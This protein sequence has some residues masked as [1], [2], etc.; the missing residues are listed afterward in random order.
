MLPFGM[1]IVE[2]NFKSRRIT[3]YIL[4]FKNN[5]TRYNPAEIILE[6]LTFEVFN[7]NLKELYKK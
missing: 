7:K 4:R 5:I 6:K 2:D 3:K 1:K